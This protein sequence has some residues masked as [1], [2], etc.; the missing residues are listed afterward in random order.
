MRLGLL[1][2]YPFKSLSSAG[3]TDIEV[4][5]VNPS[6]I[7]LN[8]MTDI[9]EFSYVPIGVSNRLPMKVEIAVLFNVHIFI[10][11]KSVWLSTYHIY[12]ANVEQSG[13]ASP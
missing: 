8:D 6:T 3:E 9:K 2:L 13:D 12:L 10:P 1:L 5:F 4:H 11:S 7:L